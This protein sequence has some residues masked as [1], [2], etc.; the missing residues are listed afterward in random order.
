MPENGDKNKKPFKVTISDEDYLGDIDFNTNTRGPEITD[1]KIQ[2]PKFEVHIDDDDD[3]LTFEPDDFS[4]EY[5][6]EIYFSGAKPI[7]NQSV[8]QPV[9]EPKKKKKKK[10]GGYGALSIFLIVM[11]LMTSGL[12]VFGISC[13]NDVLAFNRGEDSVNV[14]VPLDADTDQIID[15][16]ADAG[17]VKQPF[18]CKMYCKLVSTLLS[19]KE[20]VYLSGV[21]NVEKNLG[22]EGYLSKFRETQVGKDTVMVSIPEGWTIY[23]I[24][25]RLD[26]FGVCSKSKML[27]SIKGT[28]FE[29]DFVESIADDSTRTFKLEG[30]L[31]P[32][33]Y[34]FYVDG[35][36]NSVLRKFLDEWKKQWT[37]DYQKRADELGYTKDEIM[38]IASIIQ[39]EAADTEQ[40]A[41]ISS[42]I[43]N[44]LRHAASW[45]TINCDSTET[46][47][48]KYI[49]P[50][51]STSLATYYATNYN[52]YDTLGLPP[53][54][55]CNPGDAA[56]KA[57]LYPNNTG[58]YFFRH[59]NKGN[60]YL[61]RTQSEHDANANKVLHANNQN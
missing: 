17:L 61:A 21:Y 56:I 28:T 12:S 2:K 18:F 35:D 46:Y 23:Q 34:E 53:G 51:V 60:I 7:R 14:T 42:V 4:P 55:I 15:I 32:N 29:Y 5:K 39:R 6:G 30:Y 10:K 3:L 43:H 47:I 33:T 24:I 25:D 27:S 16:L 37:D 22:L 41:D 20:P 19:K 9:A 52:T 13:I 26:K 54:P 8:P 11:I 45:P 57:A 50:N 36:A 31:Y 1:V 58:Y 38:I 59:D 48:T 44:R 40:M 49:K